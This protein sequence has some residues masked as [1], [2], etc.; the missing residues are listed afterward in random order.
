MAQ[1]IQAFIDHLRGQIAGAGDQLAQAIRSIAD[2]IRTALQAGNANLGLAGT[3]GGGGGGG[4]GGAGAGG[5]V[6]HVYN[7]PHYLGN[8]RDL[9]TTL[10]QAAQ[11]IKGRNGSSGF[12]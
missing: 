6:T 5:G 7:F 2:E 11:R 1:N 9:V 12:A 8:E 3:G 4:G 10:Q